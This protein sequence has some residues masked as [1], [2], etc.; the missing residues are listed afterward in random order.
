M[1]LWLANQPAGQPIQFLRRP[2]DDEFDD[3]QTDAADGEDESQTGDAAVG[4]AN[5]SVE[6]SAQ[7]DDAEG[8]APVVDGQGQRQNRQRDNNREGGR[9]RPRWPRRND[10]PVDG[11]RDVQTEGA[12]RPA[13]QPVNDDKGGEENW[14]TPSF[15][16]RPVPIAA[17]EPETDAVETQ[18]ERRPRREARP[19]RV[20]EDV[21]AP[22]DLP[23]DSSE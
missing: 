20:R 3:E 8:T 13:D 15:L 21:V 12:V 18:P 16:T 5:D 11:Q 17:V 1:R 4:E 23:T 22:D 14:E 19:R 7:S 2:N 6:P 9:N 10:R